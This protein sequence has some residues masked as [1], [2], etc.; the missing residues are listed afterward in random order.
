M[1]P[2]QKESSKCWHGRPR[3]FEGEWYTSLF[4]HYYP[5]DWKYTYNNLDVH[6]RIPEEWHKVLPPKPGLEKLIMAETSAYEPECEDTWCSLNNTIKWDV[7]GEFGKYLSGDGIKRDFNFE[8]KTIRTPR[9]WKDE[10]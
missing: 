10:L 4:I 3:R 2:L 5:A 6:Y 1:L 8:E 7:R 9:H